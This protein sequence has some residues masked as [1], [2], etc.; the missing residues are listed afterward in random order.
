LL[1]AELSGRPDAAVLADML[2]ALV[3][4]LAIRMLLEPDDWPPERLLA[5]L[6]T[7]TPVCFSP[8]EP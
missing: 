1:A 3:D 5:V 2:V 4:G 8:Q 7:V 6:M